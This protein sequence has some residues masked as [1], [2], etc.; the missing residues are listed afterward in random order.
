MKY[1]LTVSADGTIMLAGKPFYAFGENNYG[2]YARWTEDY[3]KDW[4]RKSIPLF[5]EYNIP[6]IRCPFSGFGPDYYDRF[7]A[8]PAK[9]L[10]MMDEVIKC[11]E[12]NKLG[13]I[14]SIMWNDIAI[15]THCGEKRA[16]M[17]DPNS[18]TVA[19]A[20]EYVRTVVEHLKDSPAVWGWEIGNEYNLG[21][22]LCDANMKEWAPGAFVIGE[23]NG[24]DYFTSVELIYFYTEI[25]K[26]I[27][28]IDPDRLISNGNGEMR[29]FALAAHNEAALH[30][31]KETHLWTVD[32]TENTR[33]EFCEICDYYTPD[34]IDTF[35]FHFQ[36]ATLGSK[37]PHYI[38][39]HELFR[40]GTLS[41]TDYL[42]AYAEA[43]R[44]MKKGVYFGEYGDMMD[45]DSAPDR[46]EKF[47]YVMD[48]IC[49]A[50]IQLASA[51]HYQ[52][53]TTEGFHGENLRMIAE[54]NKKYQERGLQDLAAYWE[55]I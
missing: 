18:K 30:T 42:K 45:M 3:K 19:Y 37:E 7:D 9:Y 47:Q 21:A 28:S 25:A 16:A 53:V 41:L 31:D 46:A 8:D 20:K 13:L 40:E 29:S 6:F 34:P 27:R 4:F 49:A 15:P 12:E 33:D 2:T 54:M 26:V 44:R 11:A 10:G 24:F 51:W 38:L 22:D 36:H 48:C 35:S 52:D 17:G 1:G 55:K 5:K 14:V 23:M 50:D 39:E 43:G 32:F